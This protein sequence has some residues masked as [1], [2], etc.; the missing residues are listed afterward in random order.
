[1]LSASISFSSGSRSNPDLKAGFSILSG[2]SERTHIYYQISSERIVIDRSD[3]SAVAP[4]TSGINT[5][6]ETGKLRLFDLSATNGEARI[7]TL[8]LTIVVDGGIVEVHANGR[9]ALITWVWS[10]YDDSKGVGFLV[11]GSE[12]EIG[13]VSIWEGL[14][15]A[16][17]ERRSS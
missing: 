16:W 11:E 14:V 1:M 8:N 13:N 4:I 3:S 10:W 6:L 17:P 15:E 9:F 5:S 12:L 2:P 7:E